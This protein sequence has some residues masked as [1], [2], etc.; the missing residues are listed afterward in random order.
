MASTL[1]I[2]GAGF[3][4]IAGLPLGTDLFESI[5]QEIE[6]PF[7]FNILKPDIESY[8]KFRKEADGY[9]IG[10]HEINLEEFIAFLGIQTMIKPAYTGRALLQKQLLS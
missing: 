1:Y 5:L 9:E 4:Q 10:I 8:V 2:L 3:S 6:Y 7:F